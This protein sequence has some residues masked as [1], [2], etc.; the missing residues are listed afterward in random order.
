MEFATLVA[1]LARRRVVF[2]GELHDR[3]DHHL[4]QLEIVCRLRGHGPLAIGLELFQAPAQPALDRYVTAHGD[5]QTLLAESEWF[6]RQGHD[7]RLYAPILE[8]AHAHRVPLVALDVP[9]E[10]VHRVARDGL[11]SLDAA[12]RGRL[13]KVFESHP[14]SDRRRYQHFLEAQLLWDEGMAQRAADYLLA[15]P[16]RRLVVL[17]GEGHIAYGDPIPDRLSR[18]VAGPWA[19]VLQSHPDEPGPEASDYRLQSQARTLPPAGRLGVRLADAPAGLRIT[20]FDEASPARDA[21][22]EAG[23]VLTVVDGHAIGGWPAMRLALWR[24]RPGDPVTVSVA[25]GGDTWTLTFALR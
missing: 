19:L 9:G 10:L 8:F 15:H 4:N 20:G 22:L 2:V 18:R 16:Q 11:A 12:A 5:L 21:G 17:A 25:R 6:S 24:K 14:G 13:R 23:D 1:E 7:P 3:Y